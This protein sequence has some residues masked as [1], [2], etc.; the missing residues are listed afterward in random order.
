[1]PVPLLVPCPMPRVHLRLALPFP[2]AST[3]APSC[4]ARWRART[5]ETSACQHVASH[6]ARPDVRVMVHQLH[7]R[8]VLNLLSAVL[9]LTSLA[10]GTSRTTRLRSAAGMTGTVARRPMGLRRPMAPMARRRPSR[11]ATSPSPT[12][13]TTRRATLCSSATSATGCVSCPTEDSPSMLFLP[14]KT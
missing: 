10:T 12:R 8:S 9:M 5:C 11:R 13:R 7:G 4:A 2:A 14:Q 3:R 1:M 6:A